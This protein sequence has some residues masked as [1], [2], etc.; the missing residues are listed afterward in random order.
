MTIKSWKWQALALATVCITGWSARADELR[1][2]PSAVAAS[3]IEARAKEAPAIKAARDSQPSEI[4]PD[5]RPVP[6]IAIPLR[7]G[8]RPTSS[9]PGEAAPVDDDVARCI[10]MKSRAERR[11]CLVRRPG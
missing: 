11:D 7:R 4:R 1:P 5:S 2:S 8:V 3:G 9:T 6:Q 10:A